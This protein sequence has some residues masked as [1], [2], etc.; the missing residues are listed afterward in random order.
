MT[1]YDWFILCSCIRE[2][3]FWH[4]MLLHEIDTLG[5]CCVVKLC[6]RTVV[7]QARICH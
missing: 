3:E 5:D 4:T 6:A 2:C 1:R 7:K